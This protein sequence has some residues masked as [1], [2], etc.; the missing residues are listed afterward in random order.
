[1]SDI[2]L[3]DAIAALSGPV[4]IRGER[5]GFAKRRGVPDSV[6][7]V[8]PSDDR[9]HCHPLPILVELEGSFNGARADFKK[10]ASRHND[11]KYQYT[12]EFPVLG[13]NSRDRIFRPIQYEVIGIRANMLSNKNSISEQEMHRGLGTWFERFTSSFDVD[14]TVRDYLNPSII[15]WEL[16]FTMFG[17]DFSTEVPFI[18]GDDHAIT[19]DVLRR[20]SPPTIPGVV[21]VNGKT[22]SRVHSIYSHQTAIEFPT[23]H[24]IRFRDIKPIPPP[25]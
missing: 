18:V 15:E 24:P 9:F 6:F 16:Q 5:R 7:W 17:H 4:S 11:A 14:L 8:K 23:I 25:P 1:M 3:H 22:D 19:E 12:L 20:V 2:H 10:F 21:V 13:V